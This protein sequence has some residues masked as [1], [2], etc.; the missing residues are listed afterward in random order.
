MLD[1]EF[2][3]VAISMIAAGNDIIDDIIMTA[4]GRTPATIPPTRMFPV[5]NITSVMA[6]RTSATTEKI[7]YILL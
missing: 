3:A 4:N 7:E 6:R 5:G 1:I 2:M